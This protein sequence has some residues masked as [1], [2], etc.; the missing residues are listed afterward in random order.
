[1]LERNLKDVYVTDHKPVTKK[2]VTQS[3]EEDLEYYNYI[4]GLELYNEQKPKSTRINS[5][6]SGMYERGSL[7]QR[8]FE[9]FAHAK[10]LEN[11]TLYLEL[12]DRDMG[13]NLEESALR[14]KYEKVKDIEAIE[15]ADDGETRAAMFDEIE[16]KGGY[17]MEEWDKILAREFDTFA[18]GEKY[19][20]VT[21]LSRTF[22]SNMAMSTTQK[23]FKRLPKHVF[24]DIKKP[25]HE[26]I[27][28]IPVNP[29]NPSRA[30]PHKNFFDMRNHEDWLETR[31]AQRNINN[32]VSRHTRI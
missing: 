4:K 13:G 30:Y 32:T 28:E 7:K 9:P 14:A 18:Q 19:D 26:E 21:D 10:T 2:F 25:V 31:I 8:I 3:E 27:R 11:G 17:D 16:E 23:A 24:W 15:A 29:W 6:E 1:M 12:D 20:Y 22:G 5:L